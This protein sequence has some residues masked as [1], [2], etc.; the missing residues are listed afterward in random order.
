MAHRL[1]SQRCLRDRRRR[2]RG[3]AVYRASRC[4]GCLISRRRHRHPTLRRQ[5]VVDDTRRYECPHNQRSG[6]EIE[7]SREP[8]TGDVTNSPKRPC[9]EQSTALS[10]TRRQWRHDQRGEDKVDADQL[11]GQR[12]NAREQDVKPGAPNPSSCAKPHCQHSRIHDG[13]DEELLWLDPQDLTD[14]R[15]RRC[16]LP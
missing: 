13:C 7:R 8:D 2:S 5:R 6:R 14:Q 12:D 16:S 1:A 9:A 10:L 4:D 11:H 15:S 3:I